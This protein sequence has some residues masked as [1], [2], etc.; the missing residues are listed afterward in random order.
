MDCIIWECLE[1]GDT[2]SILLVSFGMLRWDCGI[3]LHQ[4]GTPG[5]EEEIETRHEV[6]TVKN[7]V[8]Y[9]CIPFV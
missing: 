1:T 9:T 5:H 6:M 8:D 2:V 4:N 7:G 3:S